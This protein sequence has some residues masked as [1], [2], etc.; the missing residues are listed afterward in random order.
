MPDLR[1]FLRATF[2]KQ[3]SLCPFE[4]VRGTTRN[5]EAGYQPQGAEPRDFTDFEQV[6]EGFDPIIVE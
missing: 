5:T 6:I 2:R 3:T 1:S 4:I